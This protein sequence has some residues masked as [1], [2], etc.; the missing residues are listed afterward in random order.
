MRPLWYLRRLSLMSPAEVLSRT[1]GSAS[2]VLKRV[3]YAT[4]SP[5]RPAEL[6]RVRAHSWPHRLADR[7]HIRDQAVQR[8]GWTSTRA[9]EFLHHRF[10]FFAFHGEDFGKEIQWN[11]DYRT[12]IV[13][14]LRYG[15]SIDY[16]R[17]SL[18]G[19]IKYLWEPNRFLHL[20]ELA[21]AYYLTGNRIYAEEVFSQVDSWVASCPYP[22]GVN[23]ASALEVGIRLINWCIAYE[24]LVHVP[25]DAPDNH[26]DSKSRWLA[27]IGDHLRYLHSH[28]SR[29]SSANNHLIGELAGLFVGSI[30]FSIPGSDAWLKEAHDLLEHEAMR[31]HWPDGVN[32]EQAVRY[33]AFVFEFLLLAGILGTANGH[34]FGPGYWG[35]LER[36]AEFIRSLCSVGPE[37][38]IL[39][40]DDDGRVIAL[41]ASVDPYRT[42]LAEAALL[43]G[44]TDLADIGQSPSEQAF[45]LLGETNALIPGR[46]NTR[47]VRMSF[48][49]GGLYFRK[50][51]EA[52]LLF[53]CGPLG[54]LSLAAHGHADALSIVLSYKGRQFLVDPGTFAYH[55]HRDWRDHFRGTFA[56][57]TIRIDGENQSVIGGNFMWLRKANAHLLRNDAKSLAGWHDGYERLPDPVRHEREITFSQEGQ[58]LTVEDRLMGKGKHTLDFT[59]T[60]SPECVCT[61]DG[62]VLRA[63]NGGAGITIQADPGLGVPRLLVASADPMGGWFS[64]GLDRKIPTTTAWW[65]GTMEGTTR[66][67]TRIVLEQE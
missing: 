39:G 34:P 48:P 46:N 66:F 18:C 32:K 6:V 29:Y 22:Q 15:P 63:R 33:Q 19:D 25:G 50:E 9:D 28:R 26:R 64:P 16:R 23:W 2:K 67:T 52:V 56:H 57:N 41:D 37:L 13:A 55:T 5:R 21:K 61:Y 20:P 42:I 36:S 40:D 7:P 17:E 3:A 1:G 65:T 62:T 10:T 47:E 59:L 14:P 4:R 24:F 54:Y 60:F 43:F 30:C 27:S 44:R 58:T 8:Y 31:Q 53:D 49:E 51:R 11:R 12:G 35:T 38:P 45:W